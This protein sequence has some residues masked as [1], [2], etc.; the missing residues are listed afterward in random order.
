YARLYE[1][2]PVWRAIPFQVLHPAPTLHGFQEPRP[3]EYILL[4]GR[5]HRWK[6]VDLVIKAFQHVKHD[7]L[8]KIVGTGEDAAAFQELAAGDARIQFLGRVSDEQL[9]D[10]YA[11]ALVVP[12]VPMQEDYGLITI[13]AF[14]SKKP[15]ITCLDSGELTVFVKDFETGFVVAPD[16][17]AIAEK[18]NYCIAHP[19][20]AAT[21]GEHGWKAV[22]HITWEAIASRLLASIEPAPQSASARGIGLQ[23]PQTTRK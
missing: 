18:L 12:F 23:R 21:M 1:A 11:G 9:V 10:L 20:Q 13:E 7:I 8:L 22:G 4:P 2:D 3:G 14:K 6:R 16:P 5:L 15:V 19:Q 17:R